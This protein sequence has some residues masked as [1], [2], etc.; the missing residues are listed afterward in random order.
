MKILL[1]AGGASVL[2]LLVAACSATPTSGP[3]RPA[4]TPASG[5]GSAD[6]T[7]GSG[8]GTVTVY[9]AASLKK[10]FA[11]IGARF[12]SSHPGTTVTF[13]FAGSSDLVA[14][15]QQGAHADV[16][17]SADTRNM[18][19]ATGDKLIEGSPVIFTSNTLQIAVPPGNPG[20]VAALQDLTNPALK[21]VVCAPQVPCGAAADKV[22]A[23][24]GITVKPVS[25]EQSVTDVVNKVVTGQAD[26]GLVY[27]TDVKAAGGK[28]EGVEFPES[29]SAVNHYPIGVLAG[30]RDKPLAQAF[31]DLV[32]GPQGQQVLTDAGFVKP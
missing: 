4:G 11:E 17:A 30:S 23:T 3:G 22:E 13:S 24:A 25:E 28:V 9:A 12:E 20:K 19:K 2:L 21:V 8:S 10:T 7:D 31:V 15:L 16:F 26:T 14:Q 6:S 1:T 27:R 18:D 32:T 29:S 5:R